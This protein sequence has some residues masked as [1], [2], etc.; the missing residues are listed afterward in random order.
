MSAEETYY[1]A[2]G[3]EITP[4]LRVLDYDHRWGVVT[5]EQFTDGGLLSPGGEYFDG[6]YYVRADEDL[7]DSRGTR[8]NGERLTTKDPLAGS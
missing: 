4:G 2:D 3:V 8:F 1:T 5:E 7:P 6:W